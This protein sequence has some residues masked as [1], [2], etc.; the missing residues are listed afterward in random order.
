[1]VGV[2]ELVDPL[3]TSMLKTTEAANA[4]LN[5]KHWLRVYLGC[6]S[7]CISGDV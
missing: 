2:V 1:M 3:A 6:D 4:T 5:A 7:C